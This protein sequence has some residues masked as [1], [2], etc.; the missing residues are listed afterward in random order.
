MKK[1]KNTKTNQIILE[2]KCDQCN[3]HPYTRIN[4]EDEKCSYCDGAGYVPTEDGEAILQLIRH[5]FK[6]MH[7]DV[8]CSS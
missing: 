4:G 7:E 8:I 3:G 2:T 5:N 1:K 6:P